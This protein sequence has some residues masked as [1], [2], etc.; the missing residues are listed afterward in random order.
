MPS[1]V[2]GL[3]LVADV[4]DIPATEQVLAYSLSTISLEHGNGRR[5]HQTWNKCISMFDQQ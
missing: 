2:D 5:S 4:A 1:T 3:D